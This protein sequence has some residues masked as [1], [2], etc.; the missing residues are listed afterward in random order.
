ML[1]FGSSGVLTTTTT[2]YLHPFYEAS[3]AP[4]APVSFRVPFAGT[5]RKLRVRHNTPA[6]NGNAIVYTVRI[7]GSASSLTVSLASTSA[8]GSDLVNAPTVAAGDY[9]DVEVT[10]AAGIGTS[11]SDIMATFALD[12]S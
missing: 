9:V 3:N 12:P 2:R 1:A 7:N 8:D 11:P 6:G 5:L 4:T 10:K